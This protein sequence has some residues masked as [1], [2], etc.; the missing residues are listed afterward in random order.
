MYSIE[1]LLTAKSDIESIINYISNTLFNESAARKL[2]G[3]ILNSINSIK[4]FPFG[5]PIYKTEHKTK[6]QYRYTRTDN[7][8]ILYNVDENKKLITIF[9]VVYR[10]MNISS[11]I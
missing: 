10:R 4:I 6:Y 7:Y 3:K 9:R 8:L 11:I 2:Y 1:I 5:N